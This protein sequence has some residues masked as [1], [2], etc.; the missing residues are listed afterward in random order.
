LHARRLHEGVRGHAATV[1]AA[2]RRARPFA[3]IGEMTSWKQ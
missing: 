2:P 1:F 3:E